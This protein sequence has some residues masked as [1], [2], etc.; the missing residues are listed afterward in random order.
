[1]FEI[2]AKAFYTFILVSLAVLC[3]RETYLT[4]FDSTVHYG[5]FA[6][7]KDGLS[8]PAT[9]DSFRRLIVQQQRRLYQLY[10]T[11]PGAAKTGEFRAPGESI[12]IQ[13]VSDLGDI[14]TS[15]LDELKIEAAGINVTSVLSTLQR[16]VRPPNEIT[17]SIDQVGTAIY[18]TA[19]WPDAPKREGNGREARTFVPPQQTDVDGA[20][21][22][23]AC[24]IFLARI[25]SA[26]PVWK[27]IGD[28]DFC[29]F[30]KSLVA[31]KEYVSLRDRAV[32]DDDRKK[33]Q[34]GPLAR[35]Q[36]EVQRLLASRTNLIFAYKLSGY[37]DIER[38]GIIPAAN[39]AKIKEMLDSAEGG[40]K[41]YLKRL[42]EI[43][44]EARDADVQERI[45]YLAARRGQLTQTAQTSANTKEFLGAIE[46]IPRS[47]IGVAI[48]T[49]HPGASIGPVDTAAAG[50]LCCFVKDR[51]GKHYLLTAGYVVGNVGTMIV[52]PATIDEAPSRDVGKVAAIV[53]GIALIETSRTDLANTGITGVADMP[54]PGDT[55]KLI[56][57]TSKSVSG[58]MIGIEKS[59]LFSMG[60]ASGAEQDVIAVTRISSPGDG[61]APVLDTQERLVGIL[62]ARSNEKSL[63]LPLKDFLDRNHLN[64]L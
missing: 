10:R 7:T 9:G 8:V 2:A 28:S 13:S 5:S 20:S 33:A 34:D 53:E 29:S 40:F 42:I 15:L 1:M 47:R 6:A 27:D 49:P 43:K 59:S 31:F 64:L 32:S 58:T 48:T 35:A 25:G 60:S 3:L 54:K 50:T 24:R 26:D 62:M 23:I 18:V 46:K 22:E 56:G 12:H 63:V 19:N 17:G 38:S 52:S 51:D 11:E 44:A 30:S 36:V 39:A 55:L 37:I 45:T 14:P 61:G 41:E 16:W 21:F 4:W 57:R